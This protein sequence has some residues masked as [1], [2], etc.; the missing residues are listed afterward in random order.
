MA[1]AV[2]C[3]I[4]GNTEFIPGP[5]NRMGQNGTPPRCRKC[6]SVERHRI[7]RKVVTAIRERER[8]HKLDLLQLSNDP[9]VA[10]GWFANTELSIHGGSNS[11]DVQCID[12]PDGRYGFIVCSHIIEHVPDPRR[13]IRELCRVLNAQGLLVL[14][15]PDPCRR[16]A[17]IDWG[18]PEP[19]QHGHYRIFGR[20]FEAE[21][22][23]LLPECYAIAVE[24]TDEVTAFPDI[25]YLVTKD[26]FWVER[27]L[28][29]PVAHRLIAAPERFG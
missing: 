26:F 1:V 10:R 6:H 23:V 14:A 7:G 19:K 2:E 16:S 5:Y 21:F 11:I 12:R 24:E 27:V 28:Q 20:D 13:A 8:F 25:L 29:S 3:N 22:R 15:Y 18:F 4:C 17:T 9:I